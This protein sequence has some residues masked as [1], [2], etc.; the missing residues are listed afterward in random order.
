MLI[1]TYIDKTA[2]SCQSVFP[3]YSVQTLKSQ[4]VDI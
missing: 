2:D 3:H 1:T 4:I